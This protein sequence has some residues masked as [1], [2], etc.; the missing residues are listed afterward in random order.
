MLGTFIGCEA[1]LSIHQHATVRLRIQSLI[2]SA[3]EPKRASGWHAILVLVGVALTALLGS[4]LLWLGLTQ[5]AS[6]R[7]LIAFAAIFFSGAVCMLAHVL[8]KPFGSFA[9]RIGLAALVISIVWVRLASG[10]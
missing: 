4:V 10:A 3:L 1:N 2:R 6:S 9:S 7:Q 8:P 5:S